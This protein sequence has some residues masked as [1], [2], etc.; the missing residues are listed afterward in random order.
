M[1]ETSPDI[2]TINYTRDAAGQVTAIE[3]AKG[4]ITRITRDALGRPTEIRHAADHEAYFQYNA[5]GDLV[6]IEDSSG[7]ILYERDPHGRIT[8][9]DPGRQRQPQ[10]TPAAS[11]W[12]TATP[13]ASSP[14]SP[15]PAA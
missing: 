12:S 7:A 2:G 14:A 13:T 15:T 11:R 4:Q 3:D 9:Q 8:G 10:P 1:S 5:A 6:R